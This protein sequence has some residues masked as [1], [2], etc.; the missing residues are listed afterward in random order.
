M[1]TNSID[2]KVS[3]VNYKIKDF[4]YLTCLFQIGTMIYFAKI[5]IWKFAKLFVKNIEETMKDA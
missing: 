2:E 4:N 1:I 5:I 3:T